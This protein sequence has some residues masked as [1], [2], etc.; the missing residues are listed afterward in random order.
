[1]QSSQLRF[2]DVNNTFSKAFFLF[3]F[4]VVFI[5]Y[6]SF[7][8][9]SS[10]C[11][12]LT[13][14]FLFLFSFLFILPLVVVSSSLSSKDNTKLCTKMKDQINIFCCLLAWKNMARS[15]LSQ[16]ANIRIKAFI[17]LEYN[18]LIH[19]LG[20]VLLCTSCLF[21]QRCNESKKANKLLAK[22]FSFF[23][24]T[25][26]YCSLIWNASHFLDAYHL[27]FLSILVHGYPF[28]HAHPFLS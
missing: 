9:P 20:L 24:L 7:F 13:Y 25:Y 15:N 5:Y 22:V 8:P 18:S 14:V 2:N 12:L 1:M 17:V 28:A 27:S 19:F 23:I 26:Y 16:H 11:F 10:Y 3:F 6:L 4:L 21:E